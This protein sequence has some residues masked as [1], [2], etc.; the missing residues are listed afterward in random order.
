MNGKIILACALLALAAGA[1]AR[2]AS[3]WLL[4]ES[5]QVGEGATFA[6]DLYLDARDAPGAHPGLYAG[7]VLVSFDPALLSFNDFDP[8]GTVSLFSGPSTGSDGGLATVTLGFENAG[9]LGVVG[10]FSFTSTGPVGSV[11]SIGL[12][13]A[14]DFFGSFIALVPTNQ[15][16]YP[17]FQGTSVQTV[18]LP[19]SAWLLGAGLGLVGLWRARRTCAAA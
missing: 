10:R 12:A 17:E 16:F 15:P 13:D 11:A 2:A 18:P 19:A 4:P 8:Q 3:V 6:V 9:D 1:P 7:E 14:D 5:E